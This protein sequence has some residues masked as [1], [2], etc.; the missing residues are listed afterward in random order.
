MSTIIHT[1]EPYKMKP[2]DANSDFYAKYNVDSNEKDPKFQVSDNVKIWKYKNIFSKG[3]TPNW[4]EK[5]FLISKT[6]NTVPWTYA[7]SD[8]NGEKVIGTFHEKELQKTN[9]EEFRIKE[10]IKR[11]GNKLFFKWKGCD[12][13][14]DNWIDKVDIAKWVYKKWVNTFS[15]HIE[16]L[17]ETLM[18][19]FI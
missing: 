4:S 6:K 1:I 5:V 12:D 2:I 16:T 7:I 13:S 9:Q 18:S 10:V 11:R 14:F 15:N 8:L 3:Y 19:M 17:D